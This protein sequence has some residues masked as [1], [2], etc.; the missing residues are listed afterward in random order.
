MTADGE[1]PLADFDGL[2]K[3]HV[4]TRA[5]LAIVEAENVRHAVIR[6]LVAQPSRRIAPFDFGW[7]LRLHAEMFG[8]VW[9]WAGKG[10]KV[11]ATKSGQTEGKGASH[12]IWANWKKKGGRHLFLSSANGE[13]FQES[14]H[15]G[16]RAPAPARRTAP[17][18][19]RRPTAIALPPGPCSHRCLDDAGRR[20][21]PAVHERREERDAARNRA[22]T[23]AR[24]L[25]SKRADPATRSATRSARAARLPPPAP[26]HRS[27][28]GWRRDGRE[29]RPVPRRPRPAP[30]RNAGGVTP[31][32]S[33]RENDARLPSARRCTAWSPR[34][35]ARGH[36]P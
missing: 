3:R 2:R 34:T 6:Y 30:D 19:T 21:L 8:E 11:P 4:R 35:S 24:R 33:T 28:R 18:A 17:R 10:E 22:P 12:Q 14:R 15:P 31:R 5:Q 27:Q 36:P 25:P 29:S 20:Q 1:T 13:R 7:M 16:S 32:Q 23:I 9:S 26:S